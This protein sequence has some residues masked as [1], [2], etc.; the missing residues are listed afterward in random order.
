MGTSMI[1]S[2]DK[3]I[4]APMFERVF[5]SVDL[6]AIDN[7]AN[8][9]FLDGPVCAAYIK[10]K[11]GTYILMLAT[12]E[13]GHIRSAKNLLASCHAFMFEKTDCVTIDASISAS[14]RDVIFLAR[15]LPGLRSQALSSGKEFLARWTIG[16]WAQSV[17]VDASIERLAERPEKAE[18]LRAERDGGIRGH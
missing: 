11:L 17:G 6:A 8:Y 4:I 12:S 13:S 14:S 5:G 3:S 1:R 18:R 7:D 2:K 10:R 15:A 16:S 9:Y